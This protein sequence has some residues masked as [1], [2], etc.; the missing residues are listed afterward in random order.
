MKI[1]IVGAGMLGCQ[2]ANLLILKDHEVTV[3]DLKQSSLDKIADLKL[4]TFLLNG[5]EICNLKKTHV[6][7][8]DLVIAVTNDDE[9][10]LLIAFLSKRLGCTH[11]IARVRNLEFSTQSDYIEKAMDIDLIV[12]PEQATA[13][14]IQQ[15]L[16]EE[17]SVHLDV[18][19]GGKIVLADLHVHASSNL[20]GKTI[21]ELIASGNFLISALGRNGEIMFPDNET[22]IRKTDVLYLVGEKEAVQQFS[23]QYGLLAK[24]NE[25]KNVV[26]VGGGMA[27]YYLSK[28]LSTLGIKVTLIEIDR[29]RCKYLVNRLDKV[30]IQ[31]ADGTHLSFLK[32]ENIFH[33]DALAAVMTH[34]EE[35]LILS[36]LAKQFGV[37][38]VVTKVSQN[39]YIPIIEQ[40]GINLAVSPGSITASK[41]LSFINNEKTTSVSYLMDGAA[42]VHEILVYPGM[43]IM[44][45]NLKSL[46][47]P[48]GFIISAVLRGN[49]VLIPDE[50][51]CLRPGDLVIVFVH[52]NNKRYLKQYFGFNS[53]Q[54]KKYKWQ[55]I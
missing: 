10:N 21:D 44:N 39:H 26:V 28:S 25:I 41:I 5:V 34:D 17:R 37:H 43:N 2:L 9:T 30:L 23:N 11:T 6:D 20:S 52:Q 49:D 55:T 54:A 22:M 33:A 24:K 38:H 1:I 3:M 48:K 19:A 46:K 45:G 42:E 12:N 50:S 40:L 36:L 51:T 13:Y 47:L 18:F 29:E 8:S 7:Q 16:T 15:Y 31:N 53:Q 4:E 27:G 35:N 32:E 14:E